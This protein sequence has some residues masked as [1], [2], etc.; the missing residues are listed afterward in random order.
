MKNFCSKIQWA[1]ID[2]LVD[3]PSS[4]ASLYAALVRHYDFA[5]SIDPVSLMN[6]L[7]GMKRE[8]LITIL[9]AS[10]EGTYAKAT[11]EDCEQAR[12]LYS[13]WLSRADWGDVSV[14]EVGIWCEITLKGREQWARTANQSSPPVTSKWMIDDQHDTNTIII[15]AE[16]LAL[17]EQKLIWWQNAHPKITIVPSSRILEENVKFTLQTGAIVTQGVR[18]IYQYRRENPG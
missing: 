8:G 15:H 6:T 2:L 7:E 13:A 11:P 5:Q 12:E 17:A 1:L 4:F 3:G 9:R 16:N 10:E 18:L 14:D